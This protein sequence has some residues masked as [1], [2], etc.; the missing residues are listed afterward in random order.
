MK[1]LWLEIL[2]AWMFLRCDWR[3][4]KEMRKWRNGWN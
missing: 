4:R 3:E 1:R 2:A